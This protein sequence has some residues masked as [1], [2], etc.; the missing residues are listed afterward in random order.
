MPCSIIYGV[1]YMFSVILN[2]DRYEMKNY[3]S[4]YSIQFTN[5]EMKNL[6]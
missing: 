5:N 6:C 1:M 3:K 2:K 4:L